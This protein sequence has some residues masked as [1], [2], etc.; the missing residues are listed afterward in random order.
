MT[1]NLSEAEQH[2]LQRLQRGFPVEADPYRRLAED[3]GVTAAEVFSLTA[4]LCR[5]GVIRRLGPVLDAGALG[6]VSTLIAVEVA[7]GDV[8]DVAGFLNGF[9]EVT[10]NYQRDH[11][12]NLWCA[13]VADGPERLREVVR[14]V[15]LRPGVRRVLELPVRRRYKLRLQFPLS[16]GEGGGAG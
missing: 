1:Y 6:C 5:R 12:L 10:H 9:P 14:A 4:E 8:E 3:M 11:G 13:V 2:L 7:P 15:A 16:E